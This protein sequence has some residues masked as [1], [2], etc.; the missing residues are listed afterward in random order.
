MSGGENKRQ[1]SEGGREGETWRRNG[2]D[3]EGEGG[4][5]GVRGGRGKRG[6]QEGREGGEFW[7][8]IHVPVCGHGQDLLASFSFCFLFLLS[9]LSPSSPSLLLLPLSFLPSLSD[10][11]LCNTEQ[12]WITQ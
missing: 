10:P 9:L 3:G 8:H 12:G 2:Q 11:L 1:E 6:S 4:W 5:R 7:N